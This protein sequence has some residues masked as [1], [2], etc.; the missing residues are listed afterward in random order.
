MEILDSRWFK[1]GG[2]KANGNWR[3]N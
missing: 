3:G 1:Q 2:E